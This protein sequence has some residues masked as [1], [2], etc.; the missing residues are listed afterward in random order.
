MN[1]LSSKQTVYK[2]PNPPL[3]SICIP[4]YN[5]ERT[6]VSTLQSILNQTYQNLEIIIVDNAST[7]NTLDLVGKLT[8]PR[9]IIYKNSVNIGAEK[10]FSK[11]IE[12]ATG[13]Y[14]A[15]FHSDDLYKPEMVQKQVQAFQE[16]PSIGAV[17]TLANQINE[18]GEV[19][20]EYKLPVELK[21][22]GTYCFSEIINLILKKG[23]FLLCPSAMVRGGLYKELSPFNV[24][25]FGT[26][27]DLDM[28]WRI[29]E[30]CSITVLNEKLMNYRISKTQGGFSYNYLRTDEADF[31]KVID[32]HLS[33]KVHTIKNIP[34][35]ALNNYELH[36]YAD[37]VTR[38]VNY[39]NEGQT[40]NAKKLL[41]QSISTE[42]FKAALNQIEKPEYM[43]FLPFGVMLL[44]STYIGLGQYI[45]K[46][47]VRLRYK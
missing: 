44:V 40:Q 29:L 43:A 12:L 9:I 38:A 7:D 16:N 36:R 25:K 35:S 2:Q 22:N 3:V 33:T 31:F 45:C 24:E 26:S 20:G 15:I 18:Q 10:N 5:S 19:I 17:F 13:D 30:K 1:N 41:K 14:I 32:Y 37:N 6:I 23:N 39:I 42:I 27:A 8:D 34:D 21:N 4:V 28:W 11:C 47:F 46:M